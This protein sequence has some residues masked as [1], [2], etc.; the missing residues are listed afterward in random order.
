MPVRN[1]PIYLTFRGASFVGKPSQPTRNLLVAWASI[2][3]GTIA[4]A[5]KRR[6]INSRRLI[7]SRPRVRGQN[8]TM[9]NRRRIVKPSRGRATEATTQGRDKKKIALLTR[10][11]NE[12]VAQ[13]KA[14]YERETATSRELSEA[15]ER[16]A[17]TAQVLSIISSSPIDLEPVF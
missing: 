10:K 14:A 12:T 5:P 6:A 2:A 11:L 7:L 9:P 8:Y 13:Q 16:E 4:V 1:C 17:A 3:R 15:L